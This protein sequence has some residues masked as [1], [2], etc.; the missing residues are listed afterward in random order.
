MS[1]SH[2]PLNS[3]YPDATLAHL[4]D[5]ALS[6]F[7]VLVYQAS[8]SKDFDFARRAIAYTGAGSDIMN[9][10]STSEDL[11]YRDGAGQPQLV[12]HE[13]LY[14]SLLSH[15]RSRDFGD[16]EREYLATTL[17]QSLAADRKAFAADR[18]A[19]PAQH[20]AT[21]YFLHAAADGAPIALLSY[22]IHN[23]VKL[24]LCKRSNFQVNSH[25]AKISPLAASI[26]IDSLPAFS[27]LMSRLSEADPQAIKDTIKK[28]HFSLLQGAFLEEKANLLETIVLYSS[29]EN[30][31]PYLRAVDAL[32][33]LTDDSIDQ[34][35]CLHLTRENRGA[36]A[37]RIDVRKDW[38]RRLP[39]DS[40]SPQVVETLLSYRS[41]DSNPPAELVRVSI[42]KAC[43]P[44]IAMIANIP[45]FSIPATYEA[46]TTRK[47]TPLH[48]LTYANC[49]PEQ[50]RAC[51]DL[52]VAGGADI[53]AQDHDGY[54]PLI[55]AAANARMDVLGVLLDAGA[56]PEVKDARN[57]RAVSHLKAENKHRF[58][59]MISSLKAKKRISTVFEA[60]RGHKPG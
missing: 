36:S 10:K 22:L 27:L 52:L 45:G 12:K 48:S 29:V 56:D 20:T 50:M 9:T 30:F 21:A 41:S 15:L 53:N 39:R 18:D 54:T 14:K 4:R 7:H 58:E 49:S 19:T 35:L 37:D 51:V 28:D 16:V 32:M 57:W 59:Q 5:T 17:S 42:E 24:D 6:S 23:D 60:I 43:T 1:T 11:Q 25:Y 40:W 38:R 44:V 13:T 33:Q 34:M 47:T 46:N 31:E 55:L 26:V 2:P 3:L 8:L